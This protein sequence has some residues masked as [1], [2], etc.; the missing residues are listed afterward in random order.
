MRRQ[1]LSITRVFV[2]ETLRGVVVAMASSI[3][4]L[5]GMA[6]EQD[7]SMNMNRFATKKT[8]AQGMMD[9]CLFSSNVTQ[10]MKA[11]FLGAE[12]YPYLP[13]VVSLIVISMILQVCHGNH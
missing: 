7:Y 6:A 1:A 13:F 12:K 8:M 10:L 5:F 2:Q 3:A 4:K 9:V 11:V